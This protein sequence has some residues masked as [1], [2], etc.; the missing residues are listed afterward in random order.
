MHHEPPPLPPSGDAPPILKSA[1]EM[2]KGPWG[3]WATLGWTLVIMFGY[4]MAEGLIFAIA[5]GI[6]VGFGQKPDM[7]KLQTNG[8]FLSLALLAAAPVAI[9]LSLFLAWL[10]KGPPL[11]D[12]LALR[13]PTFKQT[14]LCAIILSV[15]VAAF[16]TLSTALGKP[17]I[18]QWMLDI[19][20][21]AKS[22]P[23]LWLAIIVAAP[24]SE[25]FIF[26]GF[27]LTGVQH[28][29]AGATV[30]VI[31]SSA[32]WAAIHAQY[33]LYGIAMIFVVGLLFG[34]VRIKSGSLLLCILLHS[35]MNLIATLQVHWHLL[36]HGQ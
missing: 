36:K 32:L 12:Y 4:L 1:G 15:F 31:L 28:S 14:I 6:S 3:F 7:H 27:L 23:L 19:Y 8:F 22:L 16:D 13:L 33:D 21:Q 17:V 10:R 5:G 30:A 26:R 18:T 24:L 20:S 29:P 35:L 2:P 25:E 34:Y 9:A 11:R